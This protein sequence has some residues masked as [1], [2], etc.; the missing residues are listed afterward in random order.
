MPPGR[1][2]GKH[3]RPCRSVPKASYVFTFSRLFASFSSFSWVY[4]DIC[5][6]KGGGDIA[7]VAN[8]DAVSFEVAP[9][10]HLNVS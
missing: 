2:A 8:R 10:R 6:E 3:L 4:F 7:S 5:L 1:E 9:A